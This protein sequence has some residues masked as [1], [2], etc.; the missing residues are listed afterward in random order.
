MSEFRVNEVVGHKKMRLLTFVGNTHT[1]V[2]SV[3]FSNDDSLLI[4]GNID[5]DVTVYDVYESKFDI[6]CRQD[7]HTRQ[8]LEAL[9]VTYDLYSLASEKGG[10]RSPTFHHYLR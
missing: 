3:R 1:Q 5:G 9:V 6:H 7:Y 8:K 10:G 2:F 4:A